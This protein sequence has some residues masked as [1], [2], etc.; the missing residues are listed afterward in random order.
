[1]RN[2][3]EEEIKININ[4]IDFVLKLSSIICTNTGAPQGTVLAPFLFSLYTAD[5]R[6]TDESCPLLKFVGDTELVGKIRNDEDALYHKQIENCVNWCDKN[7]LYLNVSE[8]KEMCIDFR[9][10]QRCPKPVYIKGEAV[11]RVETYKYL[12]VVFDSKLNWTEN[13]NSVPKKK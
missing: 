13:I 6:S 9:R 3:E 8:T 10:N 5:C 4:F 1:M 12:G 2:T 11:E 7:Y